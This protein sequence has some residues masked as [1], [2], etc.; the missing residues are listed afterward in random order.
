MRVSCS[1]RGTGILTLGGFYEL[2]FRKQ[3]PMVLTRS[4]PSL[5]AHKVNF[6]MWEEERTEKAN[7]N[8]KYSPVNNLSPFFLL[9]TVRFSV[10]RSSTSAVQTKRWKIIYRCF[11]T[12][13]G[14][15]IRFISALL[16]FINNLYC[17]TLKSV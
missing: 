4:P 1:F 6:G 11:M 7:C 17:L 12:A 13:S 8:L 10:K 5:S 16:Y 3:F 2:M 15:V 9:I 14:S